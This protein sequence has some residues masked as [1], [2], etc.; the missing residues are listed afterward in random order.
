[1]R[2]LDANLLA[3]QKKRSLDPA[4]QITLTLGA[5]EY[6]LECDRL[7]KL[8]HIEEPWRANAKEVELDNS[9]GYFTDK[10]LQ[11]YKA[12]ISYGLNTKAGKKYSDTAPM[13]VT[14]QQ[15]NSSPGQL[16]CLL[17]MLGIPDLM[18]DDEASESY[19][20]KE[21]DTKTVKTLI[22]EIAGDTGVT[23]LAC[24]NHCQAYDIVFDSEDSLIDSYQ[25]KDSFRIYIGGSRLAAIKRLLEYT[26]CVLRYGDDGKLHILEATT[27]GSVYDYE[28]SLSSGHTFWSK[29]YRKSLILPNYIV[30]KS[31]KDDDPQYSGYAQDAGSYAL[32][33]KRAYY[34]TRLQSN[35]EATSIAEAILSRYQLNAEIGSADVPMN[36][37][38]EL[39]DY[40]KVTDERENDYRMGNIGSITRAY[41]AEKRTWNMRFSLGD[42][43]VVQH[44]K[45][46]YQSIAKEAERQSTQKGTGVFD[47][48]YAKDAYIEHLSIDEIDAIWLDP[49]SNIDLSKIGD[50]LDNLPDGESYARV[51]SLHLDAGQVKLDEHIFYA[52]N[53][54]PTA[55]FDPSHDTL[56]DVPNGIAFKRAKSSS[57]TADGL[58]I[59]DEIYVIGQNYALIK[60][61]SLT[62]D[63]LVILDEVIDGTYGLVYKADLTAHHLK[64]SAAISDGSHRTVADAEKAAWDAK[65]DNMDEIDMGVT[66]GKPRKDQITAYGYLKLNANTYKDGLWY[67]EAGVHINAL[68]GI[69]IYGGSTAFTT[70]AYAGGPVQC[71]VGSDGKIYA[72]AGA[73]YLDSGGITIDRVVGGTNLMKFKYSSYYTYL[74]QGTH[75]E[76]ITNAPSIR[77]ENFDY[78]VLPKHTGYPATVEGMIYYDTGT[79]SIWARAGG[80]WKKLAP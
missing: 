42:P 8:N 32:L 29:A 69:D 25:P 2:T 78:L 79:A 38:A 68:T 41:N 17:T 36:C 44:I 70:R 22:R 4:I 59:L 51:K 15:L 14:W 37:G 39:F 53:Y 9:D 16:T 71:Y 52:N 34:Q 11:G 21:T 65:P 5:T 61:S 46:L 24:Y 6:V 54:D 63:G 20:P 27:T 73:V 60:G 12:V 47:K 74:T 26:K 66:W 67:N 80:S 18:D 58:V 23:F 62:A 33:P 13:W 48:L 57:L 7:K 30:I 43:P 76:F 75:F 50:N 40:I 45:E 19:I 55:K 64:L 1:M 35:A 77:L 31:Q 3:A 72:G 49:D 56:D 10:A 28:Y